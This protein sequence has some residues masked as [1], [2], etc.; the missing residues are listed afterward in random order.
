MLLTLS[1]ASSMKTR[2]S[3]GRTGLAEDLADTQAT[4]ADDRSILPS[5]IESKTE[6]F[7]VLGVSIVTTKD[8]L[9]DTHATWA[10]DQSSLPGTVASKMK[11]SG[12]LGDWSRV[13]SVVSELRA[14]DAHARRQRRFHHRH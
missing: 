11:Q 2:P 9:T 7:D 4:L 6:Q 1:C 10:E 13:L 14:P 3:S 5:T 8:D 12:S